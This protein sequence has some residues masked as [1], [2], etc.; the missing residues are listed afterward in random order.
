LIATAT[1]TGSIALVL[2]WKFGIFDLTHM[3]RALALAPFGLI[4]VACGGWLFKLARDETFR[5]FAL[6]FL[7]GVGLATLLA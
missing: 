1:I 5:R 6:T 3:A 7:V 2:F 4:G